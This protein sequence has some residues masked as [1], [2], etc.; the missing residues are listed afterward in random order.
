MH[1]TLAS[2]PGHLYRLLVITLLALLASVASVQA[3]APPLFA[4]DELLTLT[5]R[6]DFSA[7]RHDRGDEPEEHPATLVWHR[8][9][10]D[11]VALDVQLRTR[12]HFRRDPV[13]C[14]FP[15][16]RVN[17]KTDSAE[18]TVFQG[19]DK[20]KLVSPCKPNLS[21]YE[22]YVL[23]EYLLYRVYQTVTDQSF[24]V[25][26]ARV[27]FEDTSGGGDPFTRFA[28][29]I[30]SDEA[31]AARVHGQLVDIPE[32]KII[33]ANVL[34]PD[35]STRVA[36]FE[37]MI[38]NTDWADAEIHNVTSL[39]QGGRVA[40][41]PYDFDFSGAVETPYATP[42]PGLPITTVRQRYYRGWCWPRQ[43]M[44]ATLALFRA[45]QPQVEE[46]YRSFP[47]LDDRVRDETLVYFGQFFE[48]IDTPARAR[49]FLR[50]CRDLPR[51]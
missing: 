31:M 44:D 12:G 32:G 50:D 18:G 38:G 1:K 48:S 20:L 33:R 14:S 34:D 16:L 5:V 4:S 26:L 19:Q 10:A 7:I 36:L 8:N 25:R 13:N 29:F 6:A 39:L 35:V 28:F 3:P 24:R 42:A 49:H 43:D 21:A 27:T 47:Y 22:Q 45:A 40:P 9:E 51:G 41:V 15:P 46:L 11:S 23:R 17:F 2:P 30:E 37:Y